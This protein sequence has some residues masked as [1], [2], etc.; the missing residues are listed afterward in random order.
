MVFGLAL[1]RGDDLIVGGNIGIG[2]VTAAMSETAQVVQEYSALYEQST[3]LGIAAAQSKM[4]T[5]DLRALDDS[6]RGEESN[7]TERMMSRC[8][9]W[10]P[11]SGL[12]ELNM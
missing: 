8:F 6:N 10:F 11:I 4:P 2:D 9:T 1:A 5:G 3:G 7:R 12:G